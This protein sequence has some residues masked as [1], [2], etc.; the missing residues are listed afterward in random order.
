M[1]ALVV[2][3]SVAAKWF[4]PEA[5]SQRC[6]RL[7]NAASTLLAPDLILAEFGNLVWKRFCR[8]EISSEEASA[9]VQDFLRVPLTITP[10]RELLRS[11]LDIALAT[12][13]TVYECL[14]LALAV[15]RDAKLVTG[16]ERLANALKD[17]PYH[18]HVRWIGR[19]R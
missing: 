10:A 2:D 12:R 5:H 11:A 15:Q 14:Y 8:G 3:A 7:L 13:R 1:R 19:S 6:L 17:T 16:D 9:V 4:F 18:R